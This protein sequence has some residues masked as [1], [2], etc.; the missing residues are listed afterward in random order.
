MTAAPT[1]II[2]P[3]EVTPSYNPETGV[4]SLKLLVCPG[5]DSAFGIAGGLSCVVNTGF[6]D[7]VRSTTEQDCGLDTNPLLDGVLPDDTDGADTVII[8]TIG[9]FWLTFNPESTSMKSATMGKMY[10]GASNTLLLGENLKVGTDSR[11]TLAAPTDGSTSWASADLK[12]T[13]EATVKEDGATSQ[14]ME[15]RNH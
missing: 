5:D 7:D 4:Y 6:A 13:A 1:E 8:R 2:L 9:T 15:N 10:D 12:V 11:F 3:D 14:I